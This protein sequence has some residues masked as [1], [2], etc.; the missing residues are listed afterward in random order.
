MVSL[1]LVL[2]ALS[3]A[4]TSDAV[5]YDFSAQWCGPCRQ[6]APV[7]D[8]L[9][10]AGYPIRK[11]DIDQ[12]R[13]LASRHHVQGIPCFVMVVDGQEVGRIVGAT[14]ANE[15]QAL[16]HQA[17][18][19]P[20]Q[21]TNNQ[22]DNAPQRKGGMLRGAIDRLRGG[23]FGF[24]RDKSGGAA[25]PQ[26]TE[27]PRFN[28][29]S[30][31]TNN[32]ANPSIEPPMVQANPSGSGSRTPP[33][34][35]STPTPPSAP[36][37]SSLSGQLLA[38]SVRLRIDDGDGHS[39]GSGTIIDARQGEALVLT[40]GHLFR[41]SKGK[42][43]ITVDLFWPQKIEDILGQL[44]A[45][46]LD[47][48][49]GLISFRP[50]VEVAVAKVA[51]AVYVA[52]QGDPV[53][54]VGCNHGADPTAIRSRVLSL[55]KFLGPPN[56]QV[57][58]QPVQGRSGGGL[59]SAEGFVIGVCNAA[60]PADNQGLYAALPSVHRQLDQV[61]LGDIYQGAN[62][63]PA[64]AIVETPIESTPPKR[65][66]NQDQPRRLAAMNLD[67]MPGLSTVAPGPHAASSRLRRGNGPPTRL[68]SATNSGLNAREQ[69][70]LSV[71]QNRAAGAEVVCVIR[72]LDHPNAKSEIIILDS[73]SP[74]FL[75]KLAGEQ[76]AQDARHLTSLNVR[77]TPTR[78]QRQQPVT[79]PRTPPR[80]RR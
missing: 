25:S 66:N 75:K 38:A 57:Q 47:L 71:I 64:D 18:I 52:K 74:E 13:E 40:C 70:A 77:R 53:I 37:P 29:G 32:S 34:F 80:R 68:V 46:D 42:G 62:P 69:A 73:A 55:N 14:S 8:R 15:L 22:S 26:L 24:G 60:D 11:I 2:F 5:L 48:D 72:S 1:Q 3:T 63:S 30:A 31:T 54:S 10:S 43:P 65:T 61:F 21:A 33:A 7:V 4:A 36:R 78:G 35:V 44:I 6:M 9:A 39:V 41:D 51:P 28:P 79:P 59:F 19:N 27:A 45:Y 67:H 76:R 50:G 16:F 20:R 56:L 23:G 17:G 12:N 58:G 49:V